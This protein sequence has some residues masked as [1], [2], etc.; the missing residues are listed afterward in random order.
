MENKTGFQCSALVSAPGSGSLS[1][2]LLISIFI[3]V[4]AWASFRV[5]LSAASVRVHMSLRGN[6]N[7]MRTHGAGPGKS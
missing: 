1:A 5:P 3:L 4:V 2:L 7:C 6:C